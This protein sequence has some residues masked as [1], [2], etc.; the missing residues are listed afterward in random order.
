MQNKRL[1]ERMRYYQLQQW[2]QW[3]PHIYYGDKILAYF[4]ITEYVYINFL[5]KFNNLVYKLFNIEN[6][7]KTKLNLF[8]VGSKRR[9]KL[10]NSSKINY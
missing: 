5:I 4:K 3:K 8:P 7:N 10:K 1:N 9:M 6:K 2:N